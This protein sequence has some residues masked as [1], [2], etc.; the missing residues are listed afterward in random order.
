[1]IIFVKVKPEASCEL[2]EKI[3]DREYIIKVKAQA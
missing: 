1:M 2:V 3:S